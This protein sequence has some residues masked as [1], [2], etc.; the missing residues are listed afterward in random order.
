MGI[1]AKQ[2]ILVA[3]GLVFA[4]LGGVLGLWQMQVFVDKGNRSIEARTELPP[5]PLFDH[6]RDDGTTDDIYGKPVTVKGFYLPTE[7][8][9]IPGEGNS[10]RVLT[11]FQTT[12][13]RVVPIVRGLARRDDVPA[14]PAGVLQQTGLFLPGEGDAASSG[15][16][17][18]I[19]SVR[20]P[21]LAQRWPQHQLV[22]GFVTLSESDAAAQ[23]L[24]QAPVDLPEGKGSFQ[25]GGYA[26]QWWVFG[27]FALLMTIKWAQVLGRKERLAAEDAARIELG[28]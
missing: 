4:V 23:G 27:A 7:Q 8:L 25:N 3:V 11:A 18:E 28:K 9:I 22:P 6:V 2:T 15:R 5:T 21:L 10:V 13:G 20:M 14:P 1:R 16:P 24:A 26:L 19:G 17:G 12:A